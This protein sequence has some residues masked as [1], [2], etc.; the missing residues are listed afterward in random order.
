MF[1]KEFDLWVS[2]DFFILCG[3]SVRSYRMIENKIPVYNG[4]TGVWE[5]F[6]GDMIHFSGDLPH[7]HDI[8]GYG[9]CVARHSDQHYQIDREDFP[10]ESY[11]Q[12]WSSGFHA[13][14]RHPKVDTQK[15]Q[16]KTT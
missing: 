6:G 16:K 11:Q 2:H 1:K 5:N 13:L 8:G 15:P 10:L 9:A 14:L 4:T 3:F 12:N 7:L